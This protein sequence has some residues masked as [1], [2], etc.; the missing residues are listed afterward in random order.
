MDR[1]RRGFRCLFDAAA[2]I[3]P[4]DSPS[5]TVVARATELS[6]N[7]CYIQ[8]PAPFTAGTLVLVKI[9]HA[10]EYF[11]AK[12]TVLYVKA[13]SGM[14]VSFRDIKPYCQSTLKEWI[15]SA[16]RN[17]TSAWRELPIL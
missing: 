10:D 5:T 13:A 11:E 14:G 12:G 15:L 8:I 4:E 16:L 1:V 7:G 9:F 2:E 3:A 17:Q 6:L